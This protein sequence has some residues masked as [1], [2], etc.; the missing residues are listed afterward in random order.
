MEAVIIADDLTGANDSGVQLALHGL[1]TSVLFKLDVQAMQGQDGIVLNTDSRSSSPAEAYQRVVEAAQ[2]LQQ[3]PAKLIYK[4]IDSTLRGNIGAEL[5]AV[6]DVFQPDFLILAPAYPDNGRTTKEG[7]HYLNGRPVHE[8]DIGADKKTPVSESFIPALLAQQTEKQAALITYTELRAG[9]DVLVKRLIELRSEGIPYVVSDAENEADLYALVHGVEQSGYRVV[10]AGS[11][12]LAKC[13]SV[14]IQHLIPISQKSAKSPLLLPVLVAVGSITKRSGTQLRVLLASPNMVDVRLQSEL[15]VVEPA[16][17]ERE[18]RRANDLGIA[19]LCNGRDVV[20]HIPV[21]DDEIARAIAAGQSHGKSLVEVSDS[22]AEG[23]GEIV[24]HLLRGGDWAGLVMTGGDTANQ[25]CTQLGTERFELIN[26]VEP[27]VP[28]GLLRG[29]L[30]IRTVTKAGSFGT[31]EV[32]LKSV[33]L[34]KEHL[35]L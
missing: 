1:R 16:E 11:A 3:F 14:G 4:K 28:I 6:Y 24:S 8:T 12:G 35:R 13:L 30:E 32:L 23:I 34:L 9:K 33:M 19:A 7:V 22:I 15:L 17:R 27:G 2:F 21:D 20:V 29:G 10:W 5:D 25:I 26:E 31:D 18:I